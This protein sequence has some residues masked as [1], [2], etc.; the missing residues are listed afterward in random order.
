[1]Q[2]SAKDAF[3]VL[4]SFCK[5]FSTNA[6]PLGNGFSSLVV[7][8]G[9]GT[10]SKFYQP[11]RYG[12]E[13][14]KQDIQNEAR[15]LRSFNGHIGTFHTPALTGDVVIYEEDDPISAHFVG[16][17]PMT[18]LKGRSVE[19]YKLTKQAN[20]Q[21][22]TAY[23]NDVGSLMANIHDEAAKTDLMSLRTTTGF[24]FKFPWVK[25]PDLIHMIDLCQKWMEQ[26]QSEGFIHADM[27]GRNLRIDRNYRLQ[28][29][30]DFS[31][32]G[33]TSNHL[34]DFY[35]ITGNWLPPAIEGYEGTIGRKL[36]RAVI[37]MTQI[38][39]LGSFI[40]N[41]VEMPEPPKDLEI[42]KKDFEQWVRNTTKDLALQ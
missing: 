23:L 13:R 2:Q 10:V 18:K 26:H 22:M 34:H 8:M 5:S 40:S 28:G 24:K 12:A 16:Y 27:G 30:L 36:D 11:N 29:V 33:V 6:K 3:L 21:Q 19:W 15:I 25:D 14:N 7:D 41:L 9:D 32:S 42:R 37:E 20:N 31:F 35:S 17:I 1:M 4:K 38:Q 39:S